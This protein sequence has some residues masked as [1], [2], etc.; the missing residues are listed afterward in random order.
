MLNGDAAPEKSYPFYYVPG[1]ALMETLPPVFKEHECF[2]AKHCVGVE[3]ARASV[4]RRRR[5]GLESGL[6]RMEDPR[7]DRPAE[8]TCDFFNEN[9]HEF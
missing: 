2:S 4:R 1:S 3:I 9:Q 8:P 6:A 5:P 7:S